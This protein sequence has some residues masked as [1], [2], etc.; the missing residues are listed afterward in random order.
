[1]NI[2]TKE[3]PI[4]A[5]EPVTIVPISDLHVG[6]SAHDTDLFR[7]TIRW[8]KK[9]GAYT[10]LLGDQIDAISQA[11]RRFENDSIAE[12]FKSDLDNLHH[13]QTRSV[14]RSMKPV[15]DH[16]LGVMAGNHEHTVKKRYSYDSAA[17]IADEL[18][19]PL[20]ADPSWVRLRLARN[21]TSKHHIDMLC[22]HGLFVGGGKKYGSKVNNMRDLAAGFDADIYLGGHSHT[23]FHVS[24]IGMSISPY[25]KILEKR[26]HF[27]NT[28][29]FQRTYIN[30]DKD[31]WASRKLFMP[32]RT[33]CARIDI[34][35]KKHG[36]A[37]KTDIHV[38][39]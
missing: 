31:S 39:I 3:I 37:Y 13:A 8:I 15:Q 35:L 17:I 24:D 14:I 20:L 27:I 32:N 33:G 1:M 34:Y 25:G 26:R 36:T 5:S 29:S 4:S 19:I 2:I 11:D 21:S 7:K 23:L 22:S 12:E 30:N 10:I 16:I 28:G 18:T 38:R 9:K 6:N